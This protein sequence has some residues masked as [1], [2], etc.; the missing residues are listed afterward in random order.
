MVKAKTNAKDKSKC[1]F[2][3]RAQ[4]K[5]LGFKTKAKCKNERHELA[6]TEGAEK[7]G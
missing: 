3:V 6:L 1:G 7:D 4:R 5:R 2:S